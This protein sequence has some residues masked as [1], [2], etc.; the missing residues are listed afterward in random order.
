MIKKASQ[1]SLRKQR[2]KSEAVFGRGVYVDENTSQAAS[3]RIVRY[4]RTMSARSRLRKLAEKPEGLFRHAQKRKS[5]DFLFLSVY[6][7]VRRFS[8]TFFSI[9]FHSSSGPSSMQVW[10]RMKPRS[11]VK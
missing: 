10:G 3:V 8:G 4:R 7:M 2:I 6:R 11:G 1:S 9:S 5:D